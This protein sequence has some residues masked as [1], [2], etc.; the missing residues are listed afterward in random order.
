MITLFLLAALVLT[1]AAVLVLKGPGELELMT[2]PKN[3]GVVGA[4]L[5]PLRV[6][7]V[8]SIADAATC[9]PSD[10]ALSAHADSVPAG[11]RIVTSA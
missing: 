5:S 8:A 7:V 6:P 1:P 2:T 9:D 11:M 10:E 4:E 3:L